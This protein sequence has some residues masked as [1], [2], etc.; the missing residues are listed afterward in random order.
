[1]NQE[2]PPYCEDCIVPLTVLHI[3]AESPS[4]ADARRRACSGTLPNEPEE[5][6]KKILA[7]GDN[8]DVVR[9]LA[10]LNEV[11]LSDRI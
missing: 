4:L 8:F 6:M 3:I 7:D 11:G 5:R 2:P 10:F 9:V 1:M